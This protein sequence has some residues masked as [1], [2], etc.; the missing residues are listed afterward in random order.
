M[1]PAPSPQRSSMV[2]KDPSAVRSL[3][4]GMCSTRSRAAIDMTPRLN[5]DTNDPIV[6]YYYH[7][8]NGIPMLLSHCLDCPYI[9]TYIYIYILF[10]IAQLLFAWI[11]TIIIH[12]AVL[13]HTYI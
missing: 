2:M 4:P 6:H 11:V 7:L 1:I 5:Y 13:I 8:V 10:T 3:S 12:H 9:N